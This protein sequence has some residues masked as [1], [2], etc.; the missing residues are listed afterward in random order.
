M[1][2]SNLLLSSVCSDSNLLGKNK[3]GTNEVDDISID[4][5]RSCKCDSPVNTT[6]GFT[7]LL[8]LAPAILNR[9]VNSGPLHPPLVDDEV[10]QQQPASALIGHP[11]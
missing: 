4:F 3:G 2:V 6:F 9:V 1:V 11:V 5:D 10:R 7:V 8:M